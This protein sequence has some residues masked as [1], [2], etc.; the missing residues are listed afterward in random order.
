[1]NYTKNKGVTIRGVGHTDPRVYNSGIVL[2]GLYS[3]T[4]TAWVN[5]ELATSVETS[6]K[7]G[8]A[9]FVITEGPPL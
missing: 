4:P 8:V 1:M 9:S 6:V 2:E 5:D 3:Q 7:D